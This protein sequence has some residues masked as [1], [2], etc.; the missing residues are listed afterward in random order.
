METRLFSALPESNNP[1]KEFRIFAYGQNRGTHIGQ[2][3]DD[4]YLDEASADSII[5][6]WKRRGISLVVDYEHASVKGVATGAPAAGW[7][8]LEKRRDGLWAV[9]VRW[10]AKAE[11][12]LRAREYRYFSPGFTIANA[13]NKNWVKSVFHLALVNVPASDQQ[14]PLMR[15]AAPMKPTPQPS[16][17]LAPSVVVTQRS[18]SG[19]I[20]LM[21]GSKS[22][23]TAP[24]T[25]SD[26]LTPQEKE[27]CRQFGTSE[28]DF[29]A[30]KKKRAG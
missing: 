7:F 22:N 24:Q 15:S 6:E 8:D 25:A 11:G 17:N 20:G 10:T 4:V 29:L 19:P 16:K 28:S 5:A 1:P 26:Q 9:N 23:T 2:A 30:H 3:P 27:L 14:Q 21:G 18:S 12:F 13:N